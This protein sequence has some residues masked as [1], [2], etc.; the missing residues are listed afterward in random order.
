M[1]QGPSPSRGYE[2][3]GLSETRPDHE[4]RCGGHHASTQGSGPG[5]GRGVIRP[6]DARGADH[7]DRM[8]LELRM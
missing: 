8:V 3:M 5:T 2:P 1:S 4:T 6:C 7:E